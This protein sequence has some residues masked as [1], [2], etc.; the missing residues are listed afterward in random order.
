MN[1][2]K[3]SKNILRIINPIIK[4]LLKDKNRQI[5]KDD[6]LFY[7]NNLF[8]NISSIEKRLLIYTYHNIYNKNNSFIIKNNYNNLKKSGFSM[9]PST[10]NYSMRAYHYKNEIINKNNIYEYN[11]YNSDKNRMNLLKNNGD[12]RNSQIQKNI[13]EYLYGNKSNYY[14]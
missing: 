13:D 4:E 6:F 2:N 12:F 1:T 14:Y 11:Y 7:M 8:N 10:P 3:I 5:T 9:R